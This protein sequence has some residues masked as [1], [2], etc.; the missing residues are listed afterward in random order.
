MK[1][2]LLA[3]ALLVPFGACENAG[4]PWFDLERMKDQQKHRPMKASGFFEDGRSMRTPPEGTVPRERNLGEPEFTTGLSGNDYLEDYPVVIDENLL[5]R[6]RD[7]FTIYCAVCHGVLGD[8]ESRISA[9]MSL[10]KAPTLHS[11]RIKGF[12]PGRIYYTISKGFG[13]MPPYAHELD[14]MDRWA[15]VAYVKALQ[16]SQSVSLDSLSSDLRNEAQKAVSQP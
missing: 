12:P 9:R 10:R 7:R 6:G 13:L 1:R 2:L 4:I 14:P 5:E 16:L 8:G 11:E 15:V 3:I